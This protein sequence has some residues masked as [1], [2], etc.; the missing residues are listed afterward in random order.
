MRFHFIRFG[1]ILLAAAA[2]TT[3][4]RVGLPRGSEVRVRGSGSP[5]TAGRVEERRLLDCSQPTGAVHGKANAQHGRPTVASNGL[6]DS[7]RLAPDV[8]PANTEVKIARGS[9]MKYRWVDVSAGSVTPTP[10]AT[11]T[12]DLRG[13]TQG[14]TGLFIVRWV[15][16]LS[17]WDSVGGTVT[18]STITAN[19]T[20]LSVYAIAGG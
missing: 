6:G 11:L 9:S 4:H 3:A 7:L 8:V 15:P 14:K 16:A 18:D 17:V 12:I 19:L 13:C 2:C 20:H 5:G 1:F 10:P